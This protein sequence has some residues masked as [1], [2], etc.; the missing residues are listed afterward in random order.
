[1]GVRLVRRVSKILPKPVP[2][3][4][5]THTPTT[6]LVHRTHTTTRK[7]IKV[8]R[9]G[10]Q[11]SLFALWP[12][13]VRFSPTPLLACVLRSRAPRLRLV[14]YS[15]TDEDD[16]QPATPDCARGYARRDFSFFFGG[17]AAGVAGAGNEG[18][19]PNGSPRARHATHTHTL[20]TR[21]DTRT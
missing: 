18:G 17:M 16:P 13:C 21:H 7:V 4:K 2:D 3:P 5:Q 6:K 9:A 14:D 10:R 15:L 8:R 19:S 11:S 12:M 1:V 20:K